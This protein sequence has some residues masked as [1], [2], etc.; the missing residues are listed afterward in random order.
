M[1]LMTACSIQQTLGLPFSLTTRVKWHLENSPCHAAL[2]W[3][4]LQIKAAKLV[5]I[6]DG[7]RPSTE[8]FAT[9]S[10]HF[11]VWGWDALCGTNPTFQAA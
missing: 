5:G 8:V 2:I 11:E 7:I 10:G 4:E 6:V 9:Q 3:T 1:A